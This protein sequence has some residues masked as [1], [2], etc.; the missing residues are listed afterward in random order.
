MFFP[1]GFEN[2]VKEGS[3]INFVDFRIY[4]NHGNLAR[5]EI[6]PLLD[7]NKINMGT[8]FENP[9]NK[10]V[11]YPTKIVPEQNRFYGGL[12]QNTLKIKRFSAMLHSHSINYVY[13]R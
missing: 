6:L 2:S 7:C 12:P 9:H 10:N 1:L 3:Q 8:K 5:Y 13:C 11:V 4:K